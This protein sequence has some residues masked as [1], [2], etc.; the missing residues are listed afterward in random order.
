MIISILMIAV[1]G[2]CWVLS[3]LFICLEKGRK[4][5]KNKWIVYSAGFFMVVG[6][7]GF[8]GSALSAVGVLSWLPPS[9]E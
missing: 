2:I 9:F 6:A 3:A 7:A 1:L 5:Q 4:L 8:F